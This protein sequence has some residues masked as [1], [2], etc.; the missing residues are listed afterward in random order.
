[1]AGELHK[2]PLVVPIVT[3]ILLSF[4]T[5]IASVVLG[6]QTI[7]PSDSHIV[8][9]TVDDKT[10]TIPTRASTVQDFLT[11]AK[12]ALNEGDVVE[13]AGDT[14]VDVDNFRINVYRARTVTIFDGE[15][16]LQAL[17]A[18]TTPRS[19][20]AQAGIQ[21]YPEDEL[22]QEVSSNILKDQVIG[23]KIVIERAIP[24]NL[25][26]YGTPVDIRTHAK[27]VGELLKE[28]NITLANG[29]TVQPDISTSITSNIQVFVTRFGTQIATVEEA[30]PNEVQIVSDPSLSFG[31][32]A[33]RQAGSPGKKLVTYQLELQNGQEV[34]RRLIQEVRILEPVTQI[35]AR[36]KAISIPADKSQLMAAAGIPESEFPYAQFIINHENGMWC[37]TR[38]QGQNYCP[39]YYAEKFPGAEG[40]R[41]TGYGLCQSTPANKMANNGEDW[42]TNPVTQLKWCSDYAYRRYGSWVAAYE[43]W[44]VSKNW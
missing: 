15:K 33:I 17:S 21:V 16:R 7:G 35:T 32:Q 8:Q 30:I 2:H 38:W 20:A 19:V 22:R 42:R 14:A 4:G 44:L 10:Q 9:L 13:P 31:T 29:D 41:Q 37:P 25:N 24:A 28:K 26:L 36:G 43:H 40:D 6:S 23:E 27:T 12:V 18:A 11:R 5:M 39:P 1:M 3:L 34:G